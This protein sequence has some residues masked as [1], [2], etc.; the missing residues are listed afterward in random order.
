[1]MRNFLLL[2]LFACFLLSPAAAD[3]SPGQRDDIEEG[4]WEESYNIDKAQ[5]IAGWA[6]SE[7]NS[8]S[9][10]LG[11]YLSLAGIDSVYT[12]VVSGKLYKI[13]M[14]VVIPYSSDPSSEY[15]YETL[16]WEKPWINFRQ[17]EYLRTV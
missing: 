12:Q 13:R 9:S 5:R 6:L 3:S 14:K 17:L 15:T 4:G 11:T 10:L 1:M 8:N 16:V 2:V 7:H